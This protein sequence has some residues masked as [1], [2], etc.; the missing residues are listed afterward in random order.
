M[1]LEWSQSLYRLDFAGLAEYFAELP[2]SGF[3]PGP[4]LPKD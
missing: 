3:Q 1:R 2:D 4:E